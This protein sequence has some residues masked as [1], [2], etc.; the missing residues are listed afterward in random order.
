MRQRL[1]SPRMKRYDV[2]EIAPIPKAAAIS[3]I[4]VS[5]APSERLFCSYRVWMDEKDVTRQEIR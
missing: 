2:C 5:V 1:I 4:V 3:C